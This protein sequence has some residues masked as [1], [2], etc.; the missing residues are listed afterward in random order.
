M[1][2]A[3]GIFMFLLVVVAAFGVVF[4]ALAAVFAF[5][6]TVNPWARPKI[7]RMDVLWTML[8]KCARYVA[9]DES[10]EWFWYELE[11]R[12][13]GEDLAGDDIVF[14]YWFGLGRIGGIDRPEVLEQLPRIDAANWRDSLIERPGT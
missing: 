9:M 10:G 2:D 4:A 5:L 6:A 7:N 1:S 8:P 11:P 13:E 14:P 3:A 12:H